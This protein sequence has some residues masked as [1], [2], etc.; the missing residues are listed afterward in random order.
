[1]DRH[2]NH[3]WNMHL[4]K[5][6]LQTNVQL[7][8][9]VAFPLLAYVVTMGRVV[10]KHRLCLVPVLLNDGPYLPLYVLLT[11]LLLLLLQRLHP[12][13]LHQLL[14]KVQLDVTAQLDPAELVDHCVQSSHISLVTRKTLN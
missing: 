3:S 6:I 2:T 5:S 11:L 13:L 10:V 12:T 1:M 14:R 4:V 9:V 7:V 8:D